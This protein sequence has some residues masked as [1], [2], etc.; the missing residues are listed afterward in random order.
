[1]Q[2]IIDPQRTSTYE[3]PFTREGSYLV[4]DSDHN[5]RNTP[6][7]ATITGRGDHVVSV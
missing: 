2:R 7:M 6:N 4:S 1:M 3:R 5:A